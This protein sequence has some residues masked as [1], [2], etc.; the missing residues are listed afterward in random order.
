[1][2]FTNTYASPL[3]GLTS[4]QVR[5]AN[6]RTAQADPNNPDRQLAALIDSVPAGG[7]LDGAFFSIS[8]DPVVDAFIRAQ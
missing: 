1:M 5:A 7:T 8:V 3:Q 6:Q 2:Y 4:A